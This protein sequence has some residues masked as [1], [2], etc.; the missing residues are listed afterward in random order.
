[1]VNSQMP[2][3]VIEVSVY[4]QRDMFMDKS[5][6]SDKVAGIVYPIPL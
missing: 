4:K 1:M 2:F 5:R 3:I 6:H